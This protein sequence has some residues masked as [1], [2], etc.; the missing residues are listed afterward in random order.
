LESE[1]DRFQS[2]LTLLRL[3]VNRLDSQLDEQRQ[4]AKAMTEEYHTMV[5]STAKHIEEVQ[6][7]FQ[8]NE[9]V[10]QLTFKCT[11]HWSIRRVL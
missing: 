7:E 8:R 5:D 3:D 1:I 9:E 10:W 4:A 11:Y 6:A 2:E